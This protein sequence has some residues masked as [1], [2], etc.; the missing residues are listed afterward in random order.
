MERFTYWLDDGI[1]GAGKPGRDCFTQLARY[2]DTGLD[3]EQIFIMDALYSEKCKE[4]AALKEKLEVLQKSNA[5]KD[6]DEKPLLPFSWVK[7]C[8]TS[9]K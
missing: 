5:I 7:E 8:S 9:D 2:E 1:H 3:P 4:V 6:S